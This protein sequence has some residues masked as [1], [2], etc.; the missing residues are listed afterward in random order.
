MRNSSILHRTN[1]LVFL[2]FFIGWL[3]PTGAG[4]VVASKFA[5]ESNHT[6]RQKRWSFKEKL[7]LKIAKRKYAHSKHRKKGLYKIWWE[8]SN[9][10]IWA[11]LL[12]LGLFLSILLGILILIPIFKQMT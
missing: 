10:W 8:S 6:F 2:L 4:A 1:Y 5:Q 12:L 9:W 3:A 11:L 7:A